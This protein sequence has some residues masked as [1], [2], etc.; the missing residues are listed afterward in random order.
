MIDHD[1]E[2]EDMSEGNA[3]SFVVRVKLVSSNSFN[4][5]LRIEGLGHLY[6]A[7][8]NEIIYCMSDDVYRSLL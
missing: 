4:L 6:V 8:S 3:I 7:Q 5:S 2:T 1:G